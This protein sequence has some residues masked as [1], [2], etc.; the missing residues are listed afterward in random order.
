MM[1]P[2]SLCQIALFIAAST[3]ACAEPSAPA[4]KGT[5]SATELRERI[6]AIES[7]WH[8]CSVEVMRFASPKDA[9]TPSFDV[10]HCLRL[11]D[12]FR[13]HALKGAN[14]P[15]AK[16]NMFIRQWDGNCYTT[17]HSEQYVDCRKG[18]KPP[19]PDSPVYGPILREL[20]FAGTIDQFLSGEPL[21]ESSRL[22]EVHV[23]IEELADGIVAVKR[24]KRIVGSERANVAELRLSVANDLLPHLGIRY[25]VAPDGSRIMHAEVRST[26]HE[27]DE[28]SL[29]YDLLSTNGSNP[30]EVAAS[31]EI[32][33]RV[34]AERLGPDVMFNEMRVQEL[35]G[36]PVVRHYEGSE[37]KSEQEFRP[38]PKPTPE[39]WPVFDRWLVTNNVFLA[40]VL[41]VLAVRM[42]RR[43]LVGGGPANSSTSAALAIVALISVQLAGCV[44]EDRTLAI[45]I[46]RQPPAT[47]SQLG[48]FLLQFHV[49][50]SEGNPFDPDDVNAYLQITTPS[51]EEQIQPAFFTHDFEI[52]VTH[53]REVARDLGSEH[54]ELRWTPTQAGQYRWK[55]CVESGG[56]IT[57]EGGTLT[58]VE[59]DDPG[60]V[61][62]SKTDPN[63]FETSDG[64]FFYP[65]G[66]V[67]R[68]PFDDRWGSLTF[69]SDAPADNSGNDDA[70]G[71]FRTE[72]Y[73]RWFERMH[74]AGE[75]ICTVWMA[76]W[77]LG[78]EWSP[79]RE[80]YSGVGR[81][82]QKHAAQ[83]DRILQL[84]E[85]NDIRVLLFTSNHGRY[86]TAVDPEWF[87]NPHCGDE[88]RTPTAY[89]RS[90][91]CQRYE[92]HRLR[93]ILAR[94]GYSKAL[95]GISLC[96]EVTW[97]DPYHGYEALPG[98]F[99][100]DGMAQNRS[101]LPKKRGLVEDWFRKMARFVKET[102]I[103]QHPVSIQFASLEDGIEAW[104]T[105]EF[106]IV[107]NNLYRPVL[108]SPHLTEHVDRPIA[109][110]ADGGLAWS[111]YADYDKP[112]LIAE[113]GG[114]H[115]ANV[116]SALDADLHTGAWAMS[117]TDL[118]GV[119][120]FWWSNEV[121]R[122]NLYHRF[123]PIHRFWK[124]YDRRGKNLSCGEGN[125]VL[126]LRN[127]SESE[128]ALPEFAPH[129]TRY[130]TVLSNQSEA[131]AYIYHHH[132]N[133]SDVPINSLLFPLESEALLELPQS[134]IGGEYAVEFWDPDS[135]TIIQQRNLRLD[136]SVPDTRR[137]QLPNFRVDLALK[138]RLSESDSAP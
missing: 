69:D 93:Y 22:F 126:P 10:E 4:G 5:L 101:R 132:A 124:G 25:D 108:K 44:A 2:Q 97:I 33:V 60:F 129:P 20:G 100:R 137:I 38:A 11:G 53:E 65:L 15:E 122:A 23:N 31:Q 68:S 78:L 133:S 6:T 71:A 50:N 9:D 95:F 130:A 18:V 79:T 80:G 59:S 94:W 121:D 115:M 114:H 35:V 63:Y 103:H 83:L 40:I 56:Q 131:F 138:V 42:V 36:N 73:K 21:D 116:L 58:C 47:I 86:S 26:I 43:R 75:N 57:V 12:E 34:R 113:W 32:A 17:I 77:W 88:V 64:S 111:R 8:R 104:H 45:D 28:N 127:G 51:G 135:G 91:D 30:A 123:T 48:T 27:T 61:S 74:A 90:A 120:G 99:I 134:L 125:V 87:D 24:S 16:P 107:L 7:R 118:S 102:D 29:H 136:S 82:N 109:G 67:T 52:V 98:A 106:E 92:E 19:H 66:H 85:D 76:P 54:W 70:P 110:M 105:P 49:R 55:L 84:A 3:A 46:I 117:M 62:V 81:Y 128:G 37:L 89:F 112:K 14:D 13:I 96:T 1:R 72:K 41:L 119:A 39:P